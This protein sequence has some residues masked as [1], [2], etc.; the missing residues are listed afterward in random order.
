M[1]RSR[2]RYSTGLSLLARRSNG[3][4]LTPPSEAR[5]SISLRDYH[6]SAGTHRISCTWNVTSGAAM[7]QS[8][9]KEGWRRESVAYRLPGAEAEVGGCHGNIIAI[10]VI[11]VWG[12]RWTGGRGGHSCPAAECTIKHTQHI[13]K[14]RNALLQS[15]PLNAASFKGVK[16]SNSD[17][18]ISKYRL[19]YWKHKLTL[20]WRFEWQESG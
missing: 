9:W 10:G 6:A 5:C 17:I 1:W 16:M 12:G 3:L 2:S 4:L 18:H 7:G 15:S 14:G 8:W 19:V 11:W 20:V 13:K